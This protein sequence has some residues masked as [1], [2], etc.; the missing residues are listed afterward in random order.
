MA[1]FLVIAVLLFAH[2]SLGL[3]SE[4]TVKTLEGTT[5]YD[6]QIEI[7][8]STLASRMSS[9]HNTM[10]LHISALDANL[11]TLSTQID[12]SLH[13]LQNIKRLISQFSNNHLPPASLKPMLR[14]VIHMTKIDQGFQV[15]KLAGILSSVM[16]MFAFS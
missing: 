6:V 15:S 4:S 3:F 5:C 12:M 2:G 10:A 9:Y 7:L 16:E 8:Q 14:N 11:T 1:T 13:D